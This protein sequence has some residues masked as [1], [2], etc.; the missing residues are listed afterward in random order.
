[1]KVLM[2]STDSKIFE[3][4]SAVQARMIEYGALFDELHIVVYTQSDFVREK[5][6]SNVFIYPTNTKTKLFYFW[7]AYRISKKILNSQKNLQPTTYNLQPTQWIVTSQEAVTNLVAMLLKW[8]FGVLFQAQ[9]H[10]DF[11]SSYFKKESLKNW[12]RYWGYVWGIRNADCVRVVSRKIADSLDTKYPG[13]TAELATGRGKIQDT[14]YTTVPIFVDVQ[15]IKN[16]KPIL[17]KPFDFTVLWVGRLE[18][19]KNC[20][21]AIDA[22]VQ[23]ARNVPSVGLVIIGDG[24]E[25]KNLELQ[26]TSYKLQDNVLFTGWKNDI[27][28][29][30]KSADVL[31]ATSRYE[32]Y[33][34]QMVEARIAGIPVIAPDVGVAK[35]VGAYIAEH[36]ADSISRVLTQ[37]HARKLPT[38]KEYRYPYENKEQYLALYKQSFKQCLP[39]PLEVGRG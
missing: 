27:A 38:P 16:A 4:G 30:Y 9:F 1:M 6:A 36:S 39:A 37:L 8:R 31:V 18:K 11:A 3:K 21:L 5:I 19:E 10:T 20:S 28:G 33:G 13:T 2:L 23:F 32:G 17:P 25:R 14:R 15:K 24:S 34:M 26:V 29:Y 22:F 12:L 7:H 35:E